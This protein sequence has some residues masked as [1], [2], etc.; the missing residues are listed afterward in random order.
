MPF[1]SQTAALAG[2]KSNRT[3]RKNKVDIKVKGYFEELLSHN[4]P[5][6][7]RDLDEMAPKERVEILL[8][9]ARFIIPIATTLELTT[10]EQ[11]Q[12]NPTIITITRNIK[13]SEC[14]SE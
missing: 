10:P 7:Q 1:N 12:I 5:Q 14:E 9:M 8:K 3:G 4:L 6:I 13:E 2:A 11:D